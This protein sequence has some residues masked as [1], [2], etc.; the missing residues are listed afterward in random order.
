MIIFIWKI[1][2][3]LVSGYSL[4]FSPI[5][6][7]I[8]RKAIPHSVVQAA[9]AP[10]KNARDGSLSCRGVKLFNAMPINLLNSE[11]GDIPMFKNHLDIFL[12]NIPDE[13]SVSGLV[14]AARTNS[15]L[16]QIPIF[17]FLGT[18][19]LMINL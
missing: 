3:G 13:P 2:Q 16:D 7:R 4:P 14:R 5:S 19:L 10:V 17:L 8:G 1:T 9:P 11:H 15:L 18:L 12:A 6:D